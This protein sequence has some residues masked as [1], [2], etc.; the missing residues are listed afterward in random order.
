MIALDAEGR[1][2]VTRAAHRILRIEDAPAG[3]R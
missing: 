1:V 2:T 3:Q